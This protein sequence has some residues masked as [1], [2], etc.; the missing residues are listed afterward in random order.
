[1][2]NELI[3]AINTSDIGISDSLFWNEYAS[4]E[5]VSSGSEFAAQIDPTSKNIAN[6]NDSD[7]NSVEHLKL[8]EY[9]LQRSN[10]ELG[11][12]NGHGLG[13]GIVQAVL[14]L[15]QYKIHIEKTHIG[16]NIYICCPFFKM[17]QGL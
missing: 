8:I 7:Q 2:P 4:S 3:N 11:Q 14:R 15:H 17:N 10:H 16:T 1:M 13:L 5:M 9:N 12:Q 6:L